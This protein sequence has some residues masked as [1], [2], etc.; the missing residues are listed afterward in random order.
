MSEIHSWIQELRARLAEPPPTRL[1]PDERRPAAVMVPLYVNAGD[2]WVLFTRRAEELSQHKSQISFPGG[3]LELGED[4][5][6]GAV[7]ETEEELGIDRSKVL[8]IGRLDEVKTPAGFRILPYVGA[9]PYPVE[10]DV[11]EAEIAEVFAVPMS[12]LADPK[13]VEHRAV[14]IDGEPQPVS[15]YHVGRRQI[16][17]LTA[18]IVSNLLERLGLGE[19][20]A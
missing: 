12:A 6:D 10:T 19:P 20:V 11:N 9:I 1:E 8:E 18:R 15:V 14:R 17:G 2:L 13:L 3:K 5:W 7:R 16:W 4:G